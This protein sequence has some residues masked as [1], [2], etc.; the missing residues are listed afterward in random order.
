MQ[1][2]GPLNER[3]SDERKSKLGWRLSEKKLGRGLASWCAGTTVAVHVV[4]MDQG[5]SL[6]ILPILSQYS[7]HQKTSDTA[8]R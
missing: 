6:V 7:L 1:Q 2:K 5:A 8:P 3:P 4:V